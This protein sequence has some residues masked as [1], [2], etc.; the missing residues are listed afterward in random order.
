MHGADGLTSQRR[1][2]AAAASR[3]QWR[4]RGVASSSGSAVAL[5]ADRHPCRRCNGVVASK[6]D[7]RSS[8]RGRGARCVPAGP[9]EWHG[10]S[11]APE[12]DECDRGG[13]SGCA[14][15]RNRRSV[16]PRACDGSG[17]GGGRVFRRAEETRRSKWRRPSAGAHS[18]RRAVLSLA[19]RI[20]DGLASVEASGNGGT[21]RWGW[22][23]LSGCSPSSDGGN[24]NAATDG[25]G[26]CSPMPTNP[27]DRGLGVRE[28]A[29]AT[30]RPSTTR[31]ARAPAPRGRAELSTRDFGDDDGHFDDDRPPAQGRWP[32]RLSRLAGR[33]RGSQACPAACGTP[34][35]AHGARRCIPPL[36]RCLAAAPANYKR[37][38]PG[39]GF[40]APRDAG[41]TMG[42]ACTLF[43]ARPA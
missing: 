35:R 13:V 24:I 10:R 5:A 22:N 15:G 33:S 40:C 7:T 41:C 38:T 20:Q 21:C 18:F 2:R 16:R 28:A 34:A 4:S 42:Q 30:R 27:Y 32:R 9:V 11:G 17:S 36:R 26:T 29:P 43:D 19:T 23:E 8:C 37:L 3:P 31:L 14:M 39:I 6:P 25:F 12:T 1:A